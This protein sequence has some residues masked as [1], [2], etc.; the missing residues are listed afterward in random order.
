M[1][2]PKNSPRPD[3]ATLDSVAGWLETG[4]DRVAVQNPKPGSPSLHRMNRNEYANAI[5]DL[6]D[7]QVDVSALLPSDST[8]AGFD[9]IADVLGTSPALIQGYV[10]AAMKV[11][12]LAVGDLTAPAAP[13]TYRAPRGF[14]QGG[15]VDGMPLGTQGGVVARHNFPL[16]AVYEISAGGGRADV[17][18][19]GMPVQA[20][21]RG[22]I[23]L[24]IPAGP[25]TIAASTV[26]SFDSGGLDD[27]FSAPQRGAGGTTSITI[28]GPGERHGRDALRST[29]PSVACISRVPSAGEK[30]RSR[31]GDPPWLLSGRPQ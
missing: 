16:N 27:I 7:L 6:L 10:S 31:D 14:S 30:R 28:N 24:P 20:T 26:R 3:R 23:R 18:I 21:G 19:D 22:S 12:R 5:R 11:S 13:V 29:G 25:H 2:P 15:H 4:L 9:N 8:S 1:M 17:T